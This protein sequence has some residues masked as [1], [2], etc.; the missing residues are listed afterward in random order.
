[1][2]TNGQIN[3]GVCSRLQESKSTLRCEY[4]THNDRIAV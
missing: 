3:Q 1:M 4:M 2:K